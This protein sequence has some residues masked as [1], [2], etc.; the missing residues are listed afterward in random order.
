MPRWRA[1]AEGQVSGYELGDHRPIFS[2]NH[3]QSVDV[4]DR[5]Q[6]YHKLVIGQ[7][8]FVGLLTLPLC[9]AA[10]RHQPDSRFLA[11]LSLLDDRSLYF[12]HHKV[13][14]RHY[15]GD[16]PL[17]QPPVGI[18]HGL[19]IVVVDGVEREAYTGDIG[20]DLLLHNHGNARL[21]NRKALLLLIDKD[22]LIKAR[23]KRMAHGFFELVHRD[24]ECRLIAT[25]K[26]RAIEVFFWR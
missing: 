23:R 9:D 7:A 26:R 1:I 19:I 22:A 2:V 21:L 12:V 4:P 3:R 14:R 17:A 25:G 24:T 6:G 11:A 18:D 5:L 10:V 15:A 20:S 13:V 16:D 8:E